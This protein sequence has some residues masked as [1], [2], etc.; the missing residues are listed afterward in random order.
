MANLRCFDTVNA[1][2]FTGSDYIQ[3]VRRKTLFQ[4]AQTIAIG[5]SSYQKGIETNSVSPGYHTKTNGSRY[6]GP[7]YVTPNT[8]TEQNGCLIS[9]KNYETLYDVIKGRHSSVDNFDVNKIASV[10][11]SAWLGTFSSINYINKNIDCAITNLPANSNCN[12]ID[13]TSK[14][15]YEPDGNLSRFPGMIVDPSYEVF[16]PACESK[17]NNYSKN[18]TYIFDRIAVEQPQLIKYLSTFSYANES[19]FPFP[20]NFNTTTCATPAPPG[21]TGE[22]GPTGPTGETGPTGPTGE[23]GPTGPTPAPPGPTGETGPTGPTGETGPTGPISA[24]TFT[25]TTGTSFLSSGKSIGQGDN[26]L[27]AVGYDYESN[28]ILKSSTDGISWSTVT[29][30]TFLIAGQSVAYGGGVWVAVGFDNEEGGGNTILTS[31]NATDWTGV[32]ISYPLY[33]TFSHR[34]NSVAYEGGRWVAVGESTDTI[35]TSVNG[36]NWERVFGPQF[37]IS[38]SYVAYG[39]GRWVAVGQDTT[40][41]LNGGNT[42]LTS[43]DGINWSSVSGTK[44]SSKGSMVVYGG[45]RWVAVGSDGDNSNTI[46]TSLDG[47]NW[48]T[49]TGTKFLLSGSYVAYGGGR[50]VAVG[51]DSFD[52]GGNT[53]LTS[54]NGTNWVPITSGPQFSRIGISVSYG[55]NRWVA[56]GE[57]GIAYGGLN[58]ILTSENGTDWSEILGTQFQASGYS[59]LYTGNR[60]V[61]TGDDYGGGNSILYSN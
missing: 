9:A 42:I 1:N 58:T 15:D 6:I 49:V 3:G 4:N 30:N 21:P 10:N 13:Y 43:T 39:N 34:G 40:D 29:G 28:T 18:V 19:Q 47:T 45:G 57:N 24:L 14:Q 38:G 35:L 2:N 17:G 26:M 33:T 8:N 36:T 11:G 55:L 7:V 31:T 46:L 52:G 44:F 51:F 22:T 61:V 54:D 5:N 20:L 25:P 60:W 12:Y 16:Y 27:V 56:V 59:T 37:L 41:V 23:T 48:S 53:I 32:I 50:W